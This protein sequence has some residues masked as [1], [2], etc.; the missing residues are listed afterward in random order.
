MSNRLLDEIMHRYNLKNDR[1]LAQFLYASPAS[2][3]NLRAGRKSLSSHLVLRI[4]DKAHMSIE[5]IRQ[6]AKEE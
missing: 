3:C 5:E 6:L 1:H 4:Y 2:I